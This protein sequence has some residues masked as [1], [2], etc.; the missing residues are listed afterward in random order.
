[1]KFGV[2]IPT[3]D[4]YGVG[5]EFFRLVQ[6]AESFGYDSVWLGDHIIVP[7][8]A[9]EYTNPH[10]FDAI[11]CAIAG[12]GRTSRITF[13]TDVLV[14]PYRGPILLAKMAATTVALFGD[15]LLLGLGI[16][17]LKGEFEALGAPPVS[18]R[19]RVTTEYLAVMR[20]LLSG[21]GALS[22]N[23]SW[24]NFNDV[25]FGPIPKIP[26]PLLVGGNHAAS[27]NRAA[28][29]GDGWHPLYPTLE[30]YAAGRV[31][32]SQTRQICGL[33]G[34]FLYSYSCPR[35]RFLLP[36]ELPPTPL[37]RRQAPTDYNY[38]PP[39][40]FSPGGRE[41]F[42]GSAE[43]LQGDIY[44]FAEAGVEQFVLRFAKP[45][46]AEITPDR[47]VEQMNAFA[48]DVMPAFT[49]TGAH[50]R[51]TPDNSTRSQEHS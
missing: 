39:P 50:K 48:T 36:G 24:V 2:V 32:I 40:L 43:E 37:R 49:T 4:Q 22:Y 30:A 34:P 8:Y 51:P 18:E 26:P 7:G 25:H 1:M 6:A 10:W 33:D 17:Y 42:V 15:R 13:G 14:A 35:T 38:A 16:G 28:Q 12:M 5:R 45:W 44:E 47:F 20:H 46:D 11:T 23:G 31:A 21:T 9:T 19:G 27:W 29:F 41:R 3:Y